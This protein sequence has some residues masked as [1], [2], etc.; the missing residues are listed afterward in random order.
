MAPNNKTQGKKRKRNMEY[1]SGKDAQ[2]SSPSIGGQM[3]CI[4]N[5]NFSEN[6][7]VRSNRPI[8]TTPN[9]IYSRGLQRI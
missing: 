6:P 8:K 7:R 5:Q 3:M 9:E 4:K 2:Y 1:A